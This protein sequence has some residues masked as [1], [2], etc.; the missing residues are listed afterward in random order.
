MSIPEASIQVETVVVRLRR[1]GRRLVLPVLVLIALAAASGFWVGALPEPWM[2]WGA[3]A[4]AILLALLFGIGPVFAWLSERVIVTNRRVIMRRG[5]FVHHRIE[6][7]LGRVREVRLR[8][9]AW[10]RLFGSGDVELIVGNDAPTVVRD[11]PAPGLLVDAVQQLIE[12]NFARSD[13]GFGAAP[14]TFEGASGFGGTT[15]IGT[16]GDV[17]PVRPSAR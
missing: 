16:T 14:S 6:V 3:G 9:G 4:G 17:G 12:Q 8:R 2:N 7:P 13:A 15:R 1:H 11:V 5:L 10:Q